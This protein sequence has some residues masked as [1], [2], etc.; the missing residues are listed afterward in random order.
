MLRRFDR[1]DSRKKDRRMAV[2]RDDEPQIIQLST[3]LDPFKRQK[4]ATSFQDGNQL[5]GNAV[6]MAIS[7]EFDPKKKEACRAH[8]V[9]VLCVLMRLIKLVTIR[10]RRM[11]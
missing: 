7:P 11:V 2:L 10:I 1:G 3:Q 9:T 6:T 5:P 8:K 4:I